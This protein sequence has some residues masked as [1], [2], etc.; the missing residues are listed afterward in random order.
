M[1][2]VVRGACCPWG[3]LSVGRVVMGRVVH[4][5]S[6]PWASCPWGELS[7][8]RVV[9]GASCP[10][11]ELSWGEFW[12]GELSV[13]RVVLGR[14][15]REPVVPSRLSCLSYP[16]PAVMFRLFCLGCLSWPYYPSCLLWLFCPSSPVPAFLSWLSRPGCLV[17]A[18]LSQLS[19]N[20]C[21]VLF[22]LS[23]RPVPAVLFQL[24]CSSSSAQAYLSTALLTP[25]L[26]PGSPVL[27]VLSRFNH[28]GCPVRVALSHTTYANWP[29]MVVLSP[30]PVLA[31]LSLLSYLAVLSSVSYPGL[32]ILMVFSSGCCVLSHLS[33]PP[34]LSQLSCSIAVHMF[35]QSRP[36]CHVLT[37]HPLCP[38]LANLSRLTCPGWP[39]CAV[40]FSVIADA[41]SK[42]SCPNFTVMNVLLWLSHLN[43]SVP[44]ALS[45]VLPIL[46]SLSG[47]CSTYLRLDTS[48]KC[49]KL[50]YTSPQ[51][52]LE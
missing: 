12:W 51:P 36:W 15:V 18:A 17:L 49:L 9:Y 38:V 23:R 13:G 48:T 44:A 28:Q 4:G 19:Y 14:V 11:D 31:V 46:S 16:V 1:G 32:T 29:A 33:C 22:V 42:M 52:L 7:M 2:Q 45:Y 41:M 35:P 30:C 24:S 21:P 26:F 25:L 8:G 27:S 5:A 34:V 50:S 3:V 20:S 39:V 47:V 40:L 10:W 6:C 37:S 43:C